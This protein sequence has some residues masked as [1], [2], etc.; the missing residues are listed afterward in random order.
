MYCVARGVLRAWGVEERPL[1]G[2][3][4]VR[5]TSI[6][7][8]QDVWAP[9][10][11]VARRVCVQWRVASGPSSGQGAPTNPRLAW[12]LSPPPR[13]LLH[14]HVWPYHDHQHHLIEGGHWRPSLTLTA[15]ILPWVPFDWHHHP[16]SPLADPSNAAWLDPRFD[17]LIALA[18]PDQALIL[19]TDFFMPIVDDPRDFG[20]VAAANSIRHVPS[21]HASGRV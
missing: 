12:P 4:A 21:A 18:P 16:I 8:R 14:R 15:P 13:P 7:S 3:R 2:G 20:R 19:T 17:W 1:Q 11:G 6:H 10:P 5:H 9:P